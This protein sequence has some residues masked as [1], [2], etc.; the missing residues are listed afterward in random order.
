M[1]PRYIA[2]V[3]IFVSMLFSTLAIAQ[4]EHLKALPGYVQ[5]EDLTDAYG[6]PKES[7]RPNPAKHPV[8]AAVHQDRSRRG[9]QQIQVQDE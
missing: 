1:T 4:D 5:F 3:S 2:A 8:N 6:E 7:S 9:L